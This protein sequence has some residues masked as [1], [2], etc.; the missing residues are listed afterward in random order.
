MRQPLR[1]LVVGVSL[2]NLCFIGVWDEVLTVNANS[3]LRDVSAASVWAVILDTLL[4]GV[5]LAGAMTLVRRTHSPRLLTFAKAAFLLVLFL[6]IM[7]VWDDLHFIHVTS[8]FS[9]VLETPDHEVRASELNPL[10]PLLLCAAWPARSV[11][12]GRA[13][14]AF[15]FPLTFVTVGR[16]AWRLA[17]SDITAAN[18]DHALATPVG[19]AAA[20]PR[21]IVLL[22]DEMDF[23]L[24]YAERPPGLLL[25]ELD[26]LRAEALFATQAF[27]PGRRTE[28]SVPALLTG[29]PVNG[30]QR[31]GT[32]TLLLT[33]A[34][35]DAPVSW[36]AA[37][38]LFQSVHTLGYNA[39]VVGW[40]HPYCRI[41][42]AHLARCFWRPHADAIVRARGNGLG[43]QMV[44]EIRSLSPLA[45]RRRHIEDYDRLLA[46][47]GAAVTDTSLQFVFVHLPVPHNP[48][49]YD[50]D[51]GTLTV[52]NYSVY[53]YH[54]NLALADHTL[55]VLRRAL[56][57]AG[58]W[59]R[60]TIIVTADHSRRAGERDLRIPFLVKLAGQRG[61]GP[62]YRRPFNTIAM[63]DLTLA[64]LRAEIR[65]GDRLA[66]WLDE[67]P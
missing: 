51:S 7:R 2:A 19:H 23:R 58:G 62:V 8:F 24:A 29:R 12:V 67:W 39:A 16:A 57:G 15:L 36:G 17:T 6:P 21:V 5:A 25:P 48:V 37:P 52:H 13:V 56:E 32:D 40:Y 43:R 28:V 55:G 20:T 33:F 45:D 46:E 65:S 54:D 27:P 1:D 30:D 66:R 31:R 59:D 34:G 11:R 44:D 63:H 41:F 3:Y 49:I 9:R 18:A 22:F 42:A 60:A 35:S 14:V 10:L 50:R 38:G 53:G 26:R 47:A 4:L 64:L 61:P